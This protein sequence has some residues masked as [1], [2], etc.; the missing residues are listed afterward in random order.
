MKL[1]EK[2]ETDLIDSMKSNNTEKV[3]VL[4]LLKSSLKNAE[5]ESGGELSESD[6]LKV[7]EKQAKQ[8]RDSATQYRSG[9]RLDLAEKEE[10]ELLII[11]QYLPEKLSVEETAKIVDEVIIEIGASS[12]KDMGKVIKTV[13][14]R[15]GAKADGKTV[16]ELIKEK[17]V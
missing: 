7:L 8:R 16:S 9:N 17:L 4:R 5:I 2:I 1:T 12:V 11:N 14:E 6:I 15:V 13:M 3:S 10:A